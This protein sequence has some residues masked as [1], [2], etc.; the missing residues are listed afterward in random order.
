MLGVEGVSGVEF[1]TFQKK[2]NFKPAVALGGDKS[3][4]SHSE[5]LSSVDNEWTFK[6]FLPGA[7]EVFPFK[8]NDQCCCWRKTIKASRAHPL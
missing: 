5:N 3:K 1:F 7:A 4:V 2:K 6:A 8:A